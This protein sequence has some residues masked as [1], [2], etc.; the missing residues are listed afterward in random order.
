MMAETMEPTPPPLYPE[1]VVEPTEEQLLRR[2]ARRQYERKTLFI[3]MAIIAV[4]WVVVTIGMIWLSLAGGWFGVDTDQEFYRTLFNGVA[5]VV[6]ILT[7]C[8]WMLFLAIPMG[9][10]I[11]L[12]SY[13]RQQIADRPPGPKPLPFFWRID[14]IVIQVRDAVAQ[15]LPKLARPL[16]LLHGVAA[17]IKTLFKEIKKIL[18]LE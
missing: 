3:P 10:F 2:E 15:F 16:I 4:I 17:Y 5:N 11:Y 9:L 13:R 14:N 1:P 18:H 12:W 7:I 6:L 8:L